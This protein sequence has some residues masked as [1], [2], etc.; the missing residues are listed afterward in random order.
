MTNICVNT[1]I[2]YPFVYKQLS[3]KATEVA[4]WMNCE[5]LM[6]FVDVLC[7]V[8]GT[9]EFAPVETDTSVTNLP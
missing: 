7:S 9:P 2:E 1:Y 8:G 5:M 3:K 6:E 4:M